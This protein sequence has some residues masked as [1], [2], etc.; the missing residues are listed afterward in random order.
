MKNA[1]SILVVLAVVL[2]VMCAGCATVPMTKTT[3]YDVSGKVISTVETPSA[4]AIAAQAAADASR[5][6]AATSVGIAIADAAIRAGT[7]IE[8]LLIQYEVNKASAKNTTEQAKWDAALQFIVGLKGA[9]AP[10]A[11]VK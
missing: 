10:T 4:D 7:A 1:F 6:Q 2:A 11:T 8:P 3:N 5:M 9:L